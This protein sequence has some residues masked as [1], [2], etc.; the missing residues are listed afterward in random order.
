LNSE[1]KP[2]AID[3]FWQ[4]QHHACINQWKISN[5]KEWTP[6]E[7]AKTSEWRDSCNNSERKT[8]EWYDQYNID[9]KTAGKWEEIIFL[10][11]PEARRNKQINEF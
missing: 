9:V 2:I 3:T 5:K 10:Y 4:N 7:R 11:E 8:E 1:I 6:W